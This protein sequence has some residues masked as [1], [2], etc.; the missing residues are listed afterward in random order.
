MGSI[1]AL[2][3][4]LR[5]FIKGEQGRIVTEYTA[6][7]T[8]IT[9]TRDGTIKAAGELRDGKIETLRQLVQD[10]TEVRDDKQEVYD[11]KVRVHNDKVSDHTEAQASLEASLATR[12]GV[13]Q[14]ITALHDQNSASCKT[15]YGRGKAAAN[16]QIDAD[17]KYLQDALDFIA[18][19]RASFGT[20]QGNTLLLSLQEVT[21]L[22][23]LTANHVNADPRYLDTKRIQVR[24]NEEF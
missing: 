15:N 16:A 1:D 2:L 24:A 18:G 5:T 4:K 13:K 7:I 8:R 6:D 19:L 23:L 3:D 9:N 21:K 10:K 22:T 17:N 11:G 14:T 12:V 20:L